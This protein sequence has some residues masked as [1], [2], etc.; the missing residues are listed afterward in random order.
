MSRQGSIFQTYGNLSKCVFNRQSRI[1]A[2][3]KREK[4]KEKREVKEKIIKA[5]ITIGA[6][7]PGNG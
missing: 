2:K 4:R 1:H 5:T 7:S 3:E 6:H